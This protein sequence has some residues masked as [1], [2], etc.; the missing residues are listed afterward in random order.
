MDMIK[1]AKHR[2][3]FYQKNRKRLLA[4]QKEYARSHRKEIRQY[5]RKYYRLRCYGIDQ[6]TFDQMMQSQN[7]KCGICNVT[8]DFGVKWLSPH[9]DHNH[10]TGKV[11][12]LLCQKCN[13]GLGNF[14]ETPELL[15][16]AANYLKYQA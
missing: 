13:L 8:F 16:K 4:T 6:S 5:Q 2:N 15:I 14:R 1:R 3:E 7:N 11:R 12:S 10:S 9:V